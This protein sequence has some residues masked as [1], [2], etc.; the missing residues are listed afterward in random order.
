MGYVLASYLGHMG[1]GK[2]G[3][4]TRL[5]MFRHSLVPDPSCM[6]GAREGS[7]GRVW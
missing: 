6:G 2:S 1:G 7:E 4:G 5:V 3:L